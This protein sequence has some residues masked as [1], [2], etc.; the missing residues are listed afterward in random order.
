MNRKNFGFWFI[1][2]S[3]AQFA[4]SIALVSCGKTQNNCS[5]SLVTSDGRRIAGLSFT[6]EGDAAYCRS[7]ADSEAKNYCK[8]SGDDSFVTASFEWK[9]EESMW[10][11]GGL[12]AGT[13]AAFRCTK[14]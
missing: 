6:T 9:G 4:L 13:I 1:R 5:W 14:M 10:K 3:L 12:L 8:N 7:Y 2:R 11:D